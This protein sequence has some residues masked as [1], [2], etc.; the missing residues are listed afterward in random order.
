MYKFRVSALF[1]GSKTDLKQIFSEKMYLSLVNVARNNQE[2]IAFNFLN[3]F[4]E[5][6]L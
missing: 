1:R 6:E 4:T 3:K 2:M 5:R